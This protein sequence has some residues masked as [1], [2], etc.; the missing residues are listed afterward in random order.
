MSARFPPMGIEAG[1][2]YLPDQQRDLADWAAEVGRRGRSLLPGMRRNGLGTYRVSPGMSV[3]DLGIASVERLLDSSTIRAQDIGAV[4]FCH[5]MATNVPAAPA[6]I[7]STLASRFGMKRALTYSISQ[8]SC[9]SVVV[10]LRVL[11]SVMWRHPGL[12]EALI[13]SADKIFCEHYRN[14]SNYAMQ[15]DGSM[16]LWIRR[17]GLRNHIGHLAYRSEAA[18]YRGVDKGEELGRRFALNYPLLAHAMVREVMEREGWASDEVDAILPMNANLSAFSRVMDMLGMPRDKLH[19]RNI[20]RVGHMFASDPFLNFLDR[21]SDPAC[22]GSGNAVLFASA[23]TGS[24]GAVGIRNA[25][26][27]SPRA[28]PRHDT[29]NH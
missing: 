13:V 12:D 5:T 28:D 19:S 2:G 7:P 9:A 16:A 6:S 14:I 17:N 27:G 15:S 22:V 18:Y 3:E 21:F 10:A 4:I 26:A 24:F 8:Q 1:A 20:D 23:A 25:W 29:F 11:R